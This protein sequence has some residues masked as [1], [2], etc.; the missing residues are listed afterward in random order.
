MTKPFLVTSKPTLEGTWYDEQRV[1][2]VIKSIE[3]LRNF[4]GSRG[5]IKLLPWQR[6]WLSPVFGTM[7]KSPNTG[8]VRRLY[9][10]AY[11]EIPRKNGKSTLMAALGI[12]MAF[13]DDEPGAEVIC[14]ANSNRQVLAIWETA[15]HMV[16]ANP[17][18]RRRI[19]VRKTTRELVS[20][21]T[22]SKFWAASAK[23]EDKDGSNPSCVI[24]DELHEA[25]NTDLWE[26][27]KKGQGARKQPLFIS[28][29]TAGK[30]KAGICWERHQMVERTARDPQTHPFFYGCVYGK[31]DGVPWDSKEAY[32]AANPSYG[33]TIQEDAYD[34]MVHD[35]K[36]LKSEELSFKRYNLNIWGLGRTDWINLEDWDACETA[37]ERLYA[38]LARSSYFIGLDLSQTQDLTAMAMYYPF[39]RAVITHCFMPEA[40]LEQAER[41]EGRP[42]KRWSS[43]GWL[44]VT[45][46]RGVDYS[47]VFNHVVETVKTHKGF[48]GLG[49]DSWNA[50]DLISRMET[51]ENLVCHRVPQGYKTMSPLCKQLELDV[52]QRRLKHA[53][54]PL[55][56]T[57]IQTVELSQDLYGNY[58]PVKQ[59]GGG[60]RI[61]P[62]MA[63]LIAMGA[64]YKVD[65]ER[66]VMPGP[67]D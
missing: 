36:L 66:G 38:D 61:D 56:R 60:S 64:Y 22:G 63:T 6:D 42:Y 11:M 14:V 1:E 37:K 5:R 41:K 20:R 62:L 52:V 13:C 49:F 30:E 32:I 23:P 29:T 65:R 4:K 15:V 47:V 28:I 24:Y 43:E 31:P 18:L 57:A 2:K 9:Q 45:E 26:K 12:Y 67:A 21:S 3:R 7:Y 58:R 35:A 44:T 46:G 19:I 16:E 34:V 59:K 50:Q 54:D 48:L 10:E 53:G 27:L 17:V 33:H 25:K 39:K 51:E 8:N 40:T 55:L